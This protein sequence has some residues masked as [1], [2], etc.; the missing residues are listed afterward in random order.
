MNL[1]IYMIRINILINTVMQH[2]IKLYKETKNL[3]SDLTQYEFDT[4]FLNKKRS[5]LA[6]LV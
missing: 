2:L 6:S 4:N 1:L 5:Y 3:N